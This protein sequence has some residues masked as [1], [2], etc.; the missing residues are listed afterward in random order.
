MTHI[1]RFT[2]I[3]QHKQAHTHL[4]DWQFVWFLPSE[5]HRQI[6]PTSKSITI[7][8]IRSTHS[9]CGRWWLF[10]FYKFK[11]SCWTMYVFECECACLMFHTYCFQPFIR[12]WRIR[13]LLTA[14][15][16]YI[17]IIIICFIIEIHSL[18]YWELFCFV[19]R[20]A[21]KHSRRTYCELLRLRKRCM[22]SYARVP[23]PQ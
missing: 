19:D 6:N 22:C 12:S 13:S 20:C 14:R 23:V 1:S 8:F 16:N 7:V 15:I 11:L 5:P 2:W 21:A 4:S 9:N 17:V 3:V 10:A 18:I